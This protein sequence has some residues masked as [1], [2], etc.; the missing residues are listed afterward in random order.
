M[1]EDGV[2][3]TRI[4]WL[5]AIPSLRLCEAV[6]CAVSPR[7]LIPA[8]L[9]VYLYFGSTAIFRPWFESNS[10]THAADSLSDLSQSSIETPRLLSSLSSNM[11]LFGSG[12]MP[13]LI[14]SYIS[15][16]AM[17]LI[18]S[19]SAIPVMRF[20]GCRICTSSSSGL[21]AGVKLSVQSWKEILLSTLLSLILLAV[22]IVT[23]RTSRWIGSVTFES[24]ES[25]AAL[26]YVI[27]C[28]VLSG[29]WFLSLAAIAIDRCDGA[30]A[31]SRGISYVLSRW[32][33]VIVYTIAGFV[34]IK[35]TNTV[36]WWLANAASPLTNASTATQPTET[37]H[38]IAHVLRLSVFLCEIAIAYLLLRN[39]ED[40]VSLREMDGGKTIA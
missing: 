34:L 17:M 22:F 11:Q 28:F 1:N 21:L 8:A 36:F 32:Q 18:F 4:D 15:L 14:E 33:R 16:A 9:F 19:F 3:V 7:A 27:A 38:Q 37:F 30:E 10:Q 5:T 29:G 6:R 24:I 12:P 35:I 23:F 26:F 2:R 39:I 25:L 20:V 13:K 31:L 40:G